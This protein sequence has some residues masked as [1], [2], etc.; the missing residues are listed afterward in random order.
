MSSAGDIATASPSTE[1]TSEIIIPQRTSEVN[2]TKLQNETTSS[3]AGD[4]AEPELTANS[5][6]SSNKIIIIIIMFNL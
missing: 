2:V 5:Q 3:G 4:K 1:E 6:K